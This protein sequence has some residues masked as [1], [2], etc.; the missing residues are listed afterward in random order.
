M[1][2]HSTGSSNID[3]LDGILTIANIGTMDSDA[4][5]YGE[6]NGGI[7][8]SLGRQADCHKMA[9]VTKVVE[10]LSVTGR[11]GLVH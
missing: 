7:E 11:L 10:R 4:L 8:S 5:E 2:F 1:A 3:G 9:A 6:E